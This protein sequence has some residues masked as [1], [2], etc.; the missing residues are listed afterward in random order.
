MPEAVVDADTVTLEVKVPVCVTVLL[1][2]ADTVRE[3][4]TETVGDTLGVIDAVH[5]TT[6]SAALGDK[7]STVLPTPS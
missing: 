6:T 7:A 4:V 3:G 1:V 5:G 2:V